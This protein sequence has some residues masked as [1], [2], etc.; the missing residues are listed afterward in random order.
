MVAGN[1]TVPVVATNTNNN[2]KTNNYQVTVSTGSNRTLSYDLDGNLTDDG[3]YGSGCKS[4]S[5]R[6]VGCKAVRVPS[7]ELGCSPPKTVPTA[8]Q[9]GNSGRN[10]TA[11]RSQFCRRARPNRVIKGSPSS[12]HRPCWGVQCA[13]QE[14]RLTNEQGSR[15]EGRISALPAPKRLGGTAAVLGPPQPF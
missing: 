4:W 3:R 6:E 5:T 9:R 1:N 8:S 12:L 10:A 11:L 2:V 7:A 13:Q 14:R 15:C